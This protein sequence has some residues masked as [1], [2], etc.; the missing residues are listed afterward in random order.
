MLGTW[1]VNSLGRVRR[2][3]LVEDVSQEVGF[4]FKSPN[5]IQSLSLPPSCRSDVSAQLL[6][7]CHVCLPATILS[8]MVTMD[9]PFETVSKPPVKCFLL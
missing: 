9:Y 1:L 4:S 8:D 5:Q 6:L 7:Q 3:G 2:C